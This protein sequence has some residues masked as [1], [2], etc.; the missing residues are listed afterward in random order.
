MAMT[1]QVQ[2]A[3]LSLYFP[4]HAGPVWAMTPYSFRSAMSSGI[5]LY[6][7]LRSENF[8][9]ERA[10]QG[11]AE[12]KELRPLFQGN[13]YPLLKLTTTQTDWYAYQLDR[14]DLRRGCV[15][16][17]RRPECEADSQKLALYNIDPDA[18]YD[19]SLTGE[20]FIPAPWQETNG[21]RL[22][23]QEI[24]IARKPGSA[25]LRYRRK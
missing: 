9:W 20:T 16:C 15:F 13:L 1:N 14:P 8:P 12:L 23:Q 21:R 25:L 11:I 10:H 5:V 18:T 2:V 19:F 6:N 7:D 17:F 3:G 24:T 4:M 22:T